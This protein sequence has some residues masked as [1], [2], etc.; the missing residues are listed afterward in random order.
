MGSFQLACATALLVWAV[1]HRSNLLAVV[2]SFQCHLNR[3]RNQDAPSRPTAMALCHSM[4]SIRFPMQTNQDVE[5]AAEALQRLSPL[6]PMIN[7]LTKKSALQHAMCDTLAEILRACSTEGAISNKPCTK[8]LI[9][10]ACIS[11]RAKH[12]LV[13]LYRDWTVEIVPYS[14]R[15]EGCRASY[16]EQEST[17]CR[18]VGG[19][20]SAGSCSHDCSDSVAPEEE[21]ARVFGLGSCHS[22][23]VHQ[24]PKSATSQSGV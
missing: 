4:R 3:Q 18:A 23:A 16:G 6:Q 1:S 17:R 13:C 24:P 19:V 10:N 5:A 20:V 9:R 22:A 15:L 21:E 12:L 11:T 14:A 7:N 2:K 8:K